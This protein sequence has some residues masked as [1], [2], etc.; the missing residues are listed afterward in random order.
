ME[1]YYG[2]GLSDVKQY[3]YFI[4]IFILIILLLTFN[5]YRKTYKI[6]DS[7]V[8][9]ASVD[10][11]EVDFS[12]GVIANLNGKWHFEYGVLLDPSTIEVDSNK[13]LTS[14]GRWDG[15]TRN[16]ETFPRFGYA[17]YH[18]EIKMNETDAL[19]AIKVNEVLT[20]YDVYWNGEL[21]GGDGV[22]SKTEDEHV[23][24]LSSIIY[25]VNEINE[26][27]HLVLHVS[28]YDQNV[29]GLF[30]SIF[31]G[32]AYEIH[33]LRATNV[34]IEM[35]YFGALILMALYHLIIF[36]LRNDDNNSIALALFLFFLAIRGILMGER[37][38]NYMVP[39]LSYAFKM[40]LEFFCFYVAFMMFGFF[41]K[42]F[43][44]DFFNKKVW[45]FGLIYMGVLIAF[46]ILLP[47]KYASF[48]LQPFQFFTVIYACYLMY[49]IIKAAIN[50]VNGSFLILTGGFILFLATI[51]DILFARK[52]IDSTYYTSSAL[53]V[54]IFCLA[55][56]IAVEY[57]DAFTRIKDLVGRNERIN[58]ELHVLNTQLEQ[59]VNERTSELKSKN[60]KLEE[61]SKRDS[62][63]GLFNHKEIFLNAQYSFLN[64]KKFSIAMIDIDHFKQVNDQYG[65]PIGDEVLLEISEL[66]KE[67]IR[68]SDFVG[69]YGGEEFMIV[70]SGIDKEVAYKIVERIRVKIS[71]KSFTSLGIKITVSAGISSKE[72]NS[73]LNTVINKAD[74][75]LYQSKNNGRN[76]TSV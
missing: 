55:I 5:N 8:E 4:G 51:N 39:F 20:A 50:K 56:V 68:E 48:T 1:V 9:A 43:Y 6:Y 32:E 35:F 52:I 36:M 62:L 53:L 30:A 2:I 66:L 13:L 47:G 19:Y 57:S 34:G 61:L 15:M 14:P 28:N 11:T 18:M 74:Q 64:N 10:L 58:R 44:S 49:V 26:V 27:N 33:N 40:K 41:V 69:R 63:T 60:Q 3:R 37:I 38:V 12:D 59:R 31:I 21:L 42:S 67:E 46:L 76:Q 25:H 17:T 22:V 75:L 65:H 45:R 16:D 70:F 72:S 71:E 24:N 54:F 29:S 23:G 73:T 7:D